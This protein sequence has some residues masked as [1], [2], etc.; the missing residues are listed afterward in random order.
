MYSLKLIDL[1]EHITKTLAKSP[2]VGLQNKDDLSR[3]F[4]FERYSII[5]DFDDRQ[6]SI[7]SIWDD[8]QQPEKKLAQNKSG[9]T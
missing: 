4:I 2:L 9:K 6:I 7:L 3:T 8:R 5:Y 1:V